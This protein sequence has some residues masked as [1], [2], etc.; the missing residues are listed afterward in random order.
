MV[1]RTFCTRRYDTRS[2]C[3]AIVC[4]TP[5]SNSSTDTIR[6]HDF[7]GLRRRERA[8]VFPANVNRAIAVERNTFYRPGEY[9]VKRLT[10]RT[11]CQG[12]SWQK[13][14]TRTKEMSWAPSSCILVYV[15]AY[16][17]YSI[18][19]HIYIKRKR[20]KDDLYASL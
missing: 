11:D 2:R 1:V 16:H 20:K 3:Y 15:R 7:I 13:R 18:C 19:H 12:M 14:Q 8:F 5:L 4:Q 17:I 10:R 6:F 9:I